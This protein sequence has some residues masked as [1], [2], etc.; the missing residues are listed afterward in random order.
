[1]SFLEYPMHIAG[2]PVRASATSTI[3]LPY[4]GSAIA[5]VFQA[6]SALVDR[7]VEAAAAAAP[8]MREMTR[9]DRASILRLASQK[10]IENKE[11]LALAISSECGKPIKEARIEVER[12]ASTLLFSSEEARRLAGEVVPMMQRRPVRAVGG[13]QCG[14]RLV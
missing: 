7:A 5:T 4:D 1:M 2:E 14:S 8:V 12:G 11:D 3:R 10:L 13:S 6:D 9:F